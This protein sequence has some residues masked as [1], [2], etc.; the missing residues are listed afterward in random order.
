MKRLTVILAAAFLAQ[1]VAAELQVGDIPPARLGT[2][3]NGDHVDLAKMSGKV[4]VVSFWATWCPPCLK[5][6]PVLEA[7]HNSVGEERLEVIGIN[8]ED[9]RTFRGASRRLQ[10]YRM[11]L[12]HDRRG[13]LERQYGVEALPHMVIVGSDGR[14]AAIRRGY[15]EKMVYDIVDQL[16]DL[17]REQET[18]APSESPTP[19]PSAEE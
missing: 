13:L 9:Q 16:N 7:I 3:R 18:E 17:L 6:L 5:E 14:I 8:T 1:G 11:T 12:V 15:N 4:V 10:D 19:A 2:D